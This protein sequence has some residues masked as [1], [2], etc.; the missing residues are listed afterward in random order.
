MKNEYEMDMDGELTAETLAELENELREI[1]L[2][3][4]AARWL[5][6]LDGM[7]EI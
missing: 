2:D 6:R 7:D 4:Q 1:E 3:E 5:A